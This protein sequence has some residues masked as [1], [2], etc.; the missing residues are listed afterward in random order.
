MGLLEGKKFSLTVGSPRRFRPLGS[1]INQGV[2]I[3][4]L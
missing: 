1:L 3:D 2:A 4:L